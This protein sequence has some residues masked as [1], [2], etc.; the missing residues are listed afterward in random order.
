MVPAVAIA[1]VAPEAIPTT[2]RNFGR[3]VVSNIEPIYK[4]FISNP[5]FKYG[6]LLLDSWYYVKEKYYVKLGA[7]DYLRFFRSIDKRA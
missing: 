4:F 7:A 1:A 5:P 2:A 3:I 6:S